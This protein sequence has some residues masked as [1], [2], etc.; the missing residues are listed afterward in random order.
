MRLRGVNS[1]A[2]THRDERLLPYTSKYT[3]LN[4]GSLYIPLHRYQDSQHRSEKYKLPPR[5]QFHE[6]HQLLLNLKLQELCSTL[7]CLVLLS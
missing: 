1:R 5:H 6:S 4:N 3:I 2:Y 7:I